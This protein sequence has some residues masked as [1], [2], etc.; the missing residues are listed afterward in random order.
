MYG[1]AQI[2]YGMTQ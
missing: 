1:Q 2:K